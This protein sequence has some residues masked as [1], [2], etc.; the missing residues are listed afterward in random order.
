MIVS[1]CNTVPAVLNMLIDNSTCFLPSELKHCLHV[2]QVNKPFL[3]IAAKK[4]SPQVAWILV[5]GLATVGVGIT[6]LN[7]GLF[8]TSLYGLGLFLGTIY[9]IPPFRLKQSAIPAFLIIATV[10]GFLL[11]FGVYYATR[12]ALSLPFQWSPAIM[13]VYFMHDVW[14]PYGI[15]KHCSVFVFNFSFQ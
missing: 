14:L 13:W 12:S 3:P 6:A 7:F 10:R 4:L 8:I 2:S 1:I 11:N 5:I 9:S 15:C